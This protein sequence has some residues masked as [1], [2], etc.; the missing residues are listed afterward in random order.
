MKGTSPSR[1]PLGD[2]A[3]AAARLLEGGGGYRGQERAHVLGDAGARRGLQVA[4]VIE[5][6]PMK[7]EYR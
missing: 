7:T 3:R 6:R 1:Q 5:V 2:C 4:G